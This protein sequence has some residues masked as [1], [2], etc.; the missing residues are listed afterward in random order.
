MV[1]D[2][3]ASPGWF[4][5]EPDA[6][7]RGPVIVGIVLGGWLY[8]AMVVSWITHRPVRLG[9]LVTTPLWGL[10]LVGVTR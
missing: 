7:W 3:M 8:A 5:G 4:T 6:A 1:A 10:L 2:F 9:V